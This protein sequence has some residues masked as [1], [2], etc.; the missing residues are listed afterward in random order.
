MR[1]KR[2]EYAVHS[3]SGLILGGR[4][5]FVLPAT[6]EEAT[7]R[8]IEESASTAINMEMAFDPSNIRAAVKP[9]GR[10]YRRKI[11]Q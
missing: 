3:A 6:V 10:K 2:Y 11:P 9:I 7:Q 5:T 4:I 1:Y 8:A